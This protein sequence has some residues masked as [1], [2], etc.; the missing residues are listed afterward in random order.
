[1]AEQI[2]SEQILPEQK[3]PERTALLTIDKVGMSFDLGRRGFLGLG[4]RRRVRALD[5][6]SLEI[7]H[8]EILGLV[9]ESGSGKSTLGR[10]I[11][12][13]YRPSE[14]QIRFARQATRHE[15]PHAVDLGA[16][17]VFQNPSGSLNPRQRV[18]DIIAEPLIVHKADHDIAARVGELMRQV[19]LP[20]DFAERRPS[21]M[22]GGQAQRVGIARALALEPELIVCDEPISALDV[23]IQAQVLNLFAD[24]QE[25]T[26]C[27]YLFISHDLPVV[28]RLSH[29]VAIMYLGRIVEIAATS[30][31][32]SR[33]AHPYTRALIA[34]APRLEAKKLSFRPVEGEIPS[35][36]D[37]PRGCHFHPRCPLATDRCRSERP[38]AREVSPGHLSA[39]HLDM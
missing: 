28:E 22:S 2:R 34:S 4:P 33:P 10:L 16:Q 7:G 3:G 27:S 35:P 38:E 36:I 25:Q 23:S 17:I 8:G 18:R 1:M 31:L 15:G 20:P 26:G 5:D 37:P 11:V 32:F 12:G 9:G 6:V 19:G 14:G 21:E 29:R 13:L 30:E 24:I 39:C